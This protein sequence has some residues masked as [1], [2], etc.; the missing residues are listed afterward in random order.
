[1]VPLE[2]VKSTVVPAGMALPF[3]STTVVV[4]VAGTFPL[5]RLHGG[6]AIAAPPL[7]VMFADELETTITPDCRTWTVLVGLH[8]PAE[9]LLKSGVSSHNTPLNLVRSEERRVGK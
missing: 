3:T 9:L 4:K 6:I 8:V 7:I 2:V 1:M 5:M